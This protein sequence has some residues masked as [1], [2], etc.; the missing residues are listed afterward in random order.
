MRDHRP[1]RPAPPLLPVRLVALDIDGTIAPEDG[2]LSPR[3]RAAVAEARARGVRVSLATGRRPISAA[4]FAARLG[5]RDPI[6]AHQGAVIRA[7]PRRAER[8]PAGLVPRR[9]RLGPLLH[10][11]PLA[12][13]V[14]REA[15][16][17]CRANGL[18]PHVNDLEAILAAEDDPNFEDYSWFY[19]AETR[20]VPDL[21]AA[22]D[23]PMT[24]VISS[25][26]PPIPMQVVGEAR[27]VFAGRAT[28][29]VSHPRFLE[30]TAPGVNKGRAVAWLAHRWGIPVGAV[31][32]VG[33]A[34]N[35]V[36]MVGDA[37]H[38][39]AMAG[40]PDELV[41]AARY[42]APPLEEDGAARLVEALVNAAPPVAARN[43]DRLADEAHE[44]RRARLGSAAAADP[45]DAAGAGAGR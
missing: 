15:L 6:V 34:L 1:A 41:A 35:D 31:L 12:A 18:H 42:V 11:L 2:R 21:A 27:R 45:R 3:L 40:S 17:W 44:L 43:A 30:F 13:P 19:G 22:V 36:E 29:T 9:G 25:G 24:K 16:A 28:P 26:E 7:M 33:D 23:R 14:I 10:H 5:L 37:G 8:I 32:A 20:F 38:G 39:A 4:A